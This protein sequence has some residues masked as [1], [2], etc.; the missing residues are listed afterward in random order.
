MKR[1]SIVDFW[2][3]FA[4][5]LIMVHHLYYLGNP[6]K[7]DYY[8][9][10]AWIYVE[11]F[12]ILTGYFTYNHFSKNNKHGNI[13]KSGLSYT[14]TKFLPFIPYTTVVISLQYIISA[15]FGLLK[16]GNIK[17]FLSHFINYPLEVLLIGETQQSNQLLA[18]IW[19]LSSMLLVFPIFTF[20]CQ[21]KN[22]Y[23]L[24]TISG[25]YSLFYYGQV[26]LCNRIWP[27][28]LLRA[29]AGMLTGV[30][31]CI[32]TELIKEKISFKK[33]FYASVTLI[34]FICMF[35]ILF[36]TIFNL[37]PLTKWV[38]IL[39]ALG[40]GIM[41]SGFSFSSKL[42]SNFISFLGKISM[43]LFIWH[44]F[45]ATLVNKVNKLVVLS[46]PIRILLYFGGTLALS[47]VSYLLVNMIKR[48]KKTH[49]T[50]A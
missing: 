12:F 32:L 3:F 1:L 47:V 13:F 49:F 42:H 21:M 34:E 24:L 11:F 23:L 43:P 29:L 31:V 44:W 27:D 5:F 45:V 38:I 9:R 30:S 10:F 25:M 41:L 33:E 37:N 6:F 14:F 36:V 40:V 46:T 8:G 18:P 48:K 7:G 19:F 26:Q 2:K 28:D 15:P 17:S 22:K 39:F 35:F 4:A 16:S 50:A 20:I